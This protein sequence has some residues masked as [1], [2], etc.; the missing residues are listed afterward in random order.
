MYTRTIHC[1]PYEQQR[2]DYEKFLQCEDC[3]GTHDEEIQ[4]QFNSD[5]LVLCNYAEASYDID[6][7]HNCNNAPTYKPYDATKDEVR[8][9]T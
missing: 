9:K 2:F 1:I 4:I 3:H 8:K 7:H 6:R 5:E